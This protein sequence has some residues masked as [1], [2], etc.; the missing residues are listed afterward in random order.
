MKFLKIKKIFF[1]F[2][3]V[4]CLTNVLNTHNVLP[5]H[6]VDTSFEDI[7]EDLEDYLEPLY[8][9]EDMF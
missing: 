8:D 6:Y 5:E 9:L 7:N 3:S 4:L 2:M 1:T